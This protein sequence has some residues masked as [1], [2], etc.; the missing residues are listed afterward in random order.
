MGCP[1]PKVVK[2][3]EGSALMQDPE[4]WSMRSCSQTARAIRQAGD[5]EDPEGL[6]RCPCQ[7][8]GDRPGEQRQPGRAAV[9]VHGRTREQYY[10]GQADWDI[11]RQSEGGGV[12]PGDRQRRRDFSGE[13]AMT[14][15]GRDRLRRRS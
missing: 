10:S 9:A 15:E 8:G 4:S 13:K 7:C 14:D 3:G 11:I 1:V 5:G 6:R 12:H 2:N